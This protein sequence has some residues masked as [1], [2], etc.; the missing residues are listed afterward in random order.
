MTAVQSLRVKPY[1]EALAGFRSICRAEVRGFVLT[2]TSPSEIQRK[3]REKKPKIILA[4]GNDALNAV[5][6]IPGVPIIY[7]MVPAQQL[8][9][10]EEGNISGVSITIAP[11]RQLSLIRQALSP[12]RRIGVI[13]D[14]SKSG[15][16]LKRAVVSAKEDGMELITRE[17]NNSKEV[18]ALLQSLKGSVDLFWMLPDTTVV[19][20]ETVEY[21]LLFSLESRI[22]I[23]SFSEKYVEKG[24]LLSFDID[25]VDLGRQAGEMARRVL[26]GNPI[27][28][29]PPADPRSVLLTVNSKVARK[30]GR[31]ISRDMIE[32][33]KVY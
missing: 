26:A 29:I 20:P 10:A 1:N 9:A 28:G 8:P 2:E 22:P 32:K 27:T 16:F 3:I 4:I 17:T 15:S 12:V 24:A 23:V 5:R 33:A 11:E 19:T 18:P 7:V 21:L 25:P 6:R 13:Y 31:T 14:P 30:L